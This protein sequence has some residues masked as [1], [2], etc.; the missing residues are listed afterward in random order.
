M[1]YCHCQWYILLLECIAITT[2]TITIILDKYTY[3]YLLYV[4]F[5]QAVLFSFRA[6]APNVNN[7]PILPSLLY[8]HSEL[9]LNQIYD[10]LK[11]IVAPSSVQLFDGLSK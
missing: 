10:F 5:R 9:Y 1:H 3:E 6:I 8:F 2:I 11:G 4:K 7:V